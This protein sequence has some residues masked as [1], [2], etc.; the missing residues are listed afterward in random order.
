MPIVHTDLPWQVRSCSPD[1]EW[2]S[3]LSLFELNVGMFPRLTCTT[4]LV[5]KLEGTSS[6]ET[7]ANPD[8]LTL[9]Y[10]HVSSG[11]S[12]VRGT[13]NFLSFQSTY[14]AK[15]YETLRSNLEDD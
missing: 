5:P 8:V 7:R 14:C 13:V 3:R 10:R 9:R 1:H 2:P 15:L 6:I 4:V 11:L 12:V